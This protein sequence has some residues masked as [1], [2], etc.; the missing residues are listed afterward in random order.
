MKAE[1]NNEMSKKVFVFELKLLINN[2]DES[3]STPTMEK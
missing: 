1:S 2:N 3:S